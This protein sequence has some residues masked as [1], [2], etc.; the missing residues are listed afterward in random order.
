MGYV[1]PLN[2]LLVR[3]PLSSDAA[4]IATL[5]VRS[6]QSAYNGLL[7]AHYLN[8]LSASV[9]LK[10]TVSRLRSPVLAE[11]SSPNRITRSW[12]AGQMMGG[13]QTK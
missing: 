7:S 1:R 12:N 13:L 4:A 2:E 10:R 6:W 11:R 9:S 3:K 5:H 8:A